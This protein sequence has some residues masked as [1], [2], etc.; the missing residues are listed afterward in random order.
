MEHHTRKEGLLKAG[1]KEI[2]NKEEILQ[3]LEVVWEATQVVII[4]CRGHQKDTDYVSR[5][6]H[7][8]DQ[9]AKRAAEELSFLGMLE[10]ITKLLLALELPPHPELHQGGRTMCKRWKKNKRKWGLVEV[11]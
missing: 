7:L 1:G 5:G 4:Y 3:L 8:A 9:A 10:Q 6:K 11:A 2:K